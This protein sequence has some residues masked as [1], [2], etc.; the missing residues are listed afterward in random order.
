MR[1]GESCHWHQVN[2]DIKFEELE[3][4][5]I[6]RGTDFC[7]LHSLYDYE[8]NDPQMQKLTTRLSL[9]NPTND[10]IL[11][12][13]KN[14]FPLLTP[15]WKAVAMSLREREFNDRN[16]SDPWIDALFTKGT[17]DDVHNFFNTRGLTVSS[18]ESMDSK[19]MS[20]YKYQID[21]GGGKFI[22]TSVLL[23]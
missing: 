14:H 22:L 6:W 12:E 19:T 5:L 11:E 21:L 18:D 15:R 16:G 7:F 8:S 23:H 2:N 20:S 3:N 13:V 9:T 1:G 17:N 10:V 4:R